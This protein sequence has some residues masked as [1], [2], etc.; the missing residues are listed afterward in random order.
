MAQ[1]EENHGPNSLKPSSFPVKALKQCDQ[2]F[3]S[4][5]RWSSFDRCIVQIQYQNDSQVFEFS[6]QFL[7]LSDHFEQK[8]VVEAH[9]HVIID[10]CSVFEHVVTHVNERSEKISPTNHSSVNGPDATKEFLIRLASVNT[11]EV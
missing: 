10:R 5:C 3:A 4:T 9:V 11:S 1:V 2:S 6:E 8:D 7:Q